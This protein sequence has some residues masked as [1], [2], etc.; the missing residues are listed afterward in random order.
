MGML[1]AAV[2]VGC[3]GLYLEL[4][5]QPCGALLTR[6][7]FVCIG[8]QGGGGGNCDLG[9][10]SG[11]PAAL[12]ALNIIEHGR[13]VCT[14]L[15]LS[16]LLL[17]LLL[18]LRNCLVESTQAQGAWLWTSDTRG[19]CGMLLVAAVAV[20]CCSCRAVWWALYK[21]VLDPQLWTRGARGA[22]GMPLGIAPS[23]PRCRTILWACPRRREPK[24]K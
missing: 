21:A 22:S 4:V 12:G 2:Q 24:P 11:L 16:P 20:F 10:P 6:L 8:C 14:G 19:A 17:L 13:K 3:L 7:S 5:G 1:F 23:A 15:H 9:L 18:R